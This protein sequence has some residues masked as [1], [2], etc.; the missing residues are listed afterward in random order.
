MKTCNKCGI[1]YEDF[2]I[3]CPKCNIGKPRAKRV[4]ATSRTSETKHPTVFDFVKFFV[5]VIL[6]IAATIS[7]VYFWEELMQRY[8][9]AHLDTLLALFC[10]GAIICGGLLLV[11]GM[12]LAGYIVMSSGRS[13]KDGEDT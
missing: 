10:I 4:I 5:S 13:N 2:Y 9:D 1:E 11:K 7:V 8:P 3:A 12:S 6:L